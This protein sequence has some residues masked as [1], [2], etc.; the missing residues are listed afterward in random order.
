MKYKVEYCSE[1]GSPS[2]NDFIGIFHDKLSMNNAISEYIKSV[3]IPI[4]VLDKMLKDGDIDQDEY[5]DH[6]EEIE[7]IKNSIVIE[8]IK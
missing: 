4:N 3:T 8:E 5:N 6:I 7:K 2:D 1:N